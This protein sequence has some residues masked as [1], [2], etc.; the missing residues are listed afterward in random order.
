M[1]EEKRMLTR[2]SQRSEQYHEK[3]TLKPQYPSANNKMT[4]IGIKILLCLLIAV[5]WLCL[6]L[7]FKCI[8][9]LIFIVL[10]YHDRIVHQPFI[11]QYYLDL[12][13]E[14]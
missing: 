11:A 7:I 1:R 9:V 5:I 2:I 12:S 8:S 3:L 10:V 6:P 4:D 13:Q 14:D